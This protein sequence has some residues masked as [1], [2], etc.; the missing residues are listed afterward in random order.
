L[1]VTFPDAQVLLRR[2]GKLLTVAKGVFM[3]EFLR[4]L[5]EVSFVFPLMSAEEA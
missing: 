3:K 5:I 2:M 1:P 4:F